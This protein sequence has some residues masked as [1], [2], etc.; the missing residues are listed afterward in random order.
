[1]IFTP[2]VL[3]LMILNILFGVFGLIAFVLSVQIVK[4]W[5]SGASTKLQYKLEKQNFLNATLIKYIFWLKIPL[6]LFFVFTID[7]LSD[8]I[9]GAMCAAG[10]VD[11]TPYGIYLFIIKLLTLYLF[12]LWLVLHYRDTNEEIPPF[13]K[14]KYILFITLFPFL[15]LEIVLEILMF[16]GLDTSKILSCCGTLYSNATG[17]Y[18]SNLFFIATPLLLTLFYG[19]FLL[20]AFFYWLKNRYLYALSGA[21]FVVVALMSLIVFFGTYIYELPTHHCPFCFL[22]KE[23]FYVG[24]LIYA[25]LFLGSFYALITGVLEGDK[26]IKKSFIFITLYVVLVSLYP[27]LYYIRNGVWL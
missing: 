18:I 6:F 27:A 20:L 3:T 1:M 25:L 14:T 22:Q 26:N 9:T 10:I 2:E 8:I 12:G 19:N 23:Y 21:V 7:K 15:I 11:A 13:I 16:S 17:S 24:Y 5:E 4:G